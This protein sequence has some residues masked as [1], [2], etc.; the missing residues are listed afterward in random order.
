MEEADVYLAGLIEEFGEPSP[1]QTARAENFVESIR[2]AAV[3][4][5]ST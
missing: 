1:E 2:N 5:S 3:A 4:N